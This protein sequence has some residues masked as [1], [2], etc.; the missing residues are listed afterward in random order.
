MCYSIAFLLFYD[1]EK[2][3]A[4]FYYNS[5]SYDCS[6]CSLEDFLEYDNSFN[7]IAGIYE[8]DKSMKLLQSKLKRAIDDIANDRRDE[9]LF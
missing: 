9:I 2:E 6:H 3:I 8:L 1:K 5:S 7:K 4:S